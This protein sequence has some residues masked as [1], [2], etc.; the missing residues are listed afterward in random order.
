MPTRFETVAAIP[1]DVS[2]A[3]VFEPGW[4]SWSPSGLYPAVA[5]SRRP[6]D[7]TMRTLAYRP[8]GSL[9]GEG[10]QGDGL[11]AI[12]TAPD[13]PVRI[14]SGARPD[15]DVPSIRV[16][17]EGGDLLVVSADGE[18][19]GEEVDAPL[20]TALARWATGVA[21]RMAV[22]P[23]RSLPSVWCSWYCYWEDVTEEDILVNLADLDRLDLGVDVVQVDDGW[24]VGVGDW[25]TP[26]AKFPGLHQL[27]ARIRDTGRRAGIW[28]APFL[29]GSDSRLAAKRPD[30]LVRGADAGENWGQRLYSL[31]VTHPDAAEHLTSVFRTLSD[32]GFDYFKL[33]FLYAGAIPGGRHTDLE[34]LDAYRLGLR[35]IRA[36]L[37][38]GA[39]VLASG[40]PLLP[41]IGLVDGMRVSTDVARPGFPD[42]DARIGT[43][44][45]TGSARSFQNGRWWVNDPDCLMLRPSVRHREVWAQHVEDCA[46]LRACSDP[47][48]DLDSWGVTAARRLLRPSGSEPVDLV[49]RGELTGPEISAP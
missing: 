17:A 42:A 15:R 8:E 2:R 44:I 40:A 11:V 38:A 22:P 10:F 28:L 32:S 49:D 35:L 4:Q 34:P 46:A 27:P 21:E 5:T 12:R 19:S 18:V 20:G 47:L 45:A 3:W 24:A 1:C 36:A 39:T 14:F 41:S 7:R 25:L 26:N 31:D 6:V 33:D 23:V 43:A 13:E 16:R 29:V 37:P 9:P 30:W 48:A